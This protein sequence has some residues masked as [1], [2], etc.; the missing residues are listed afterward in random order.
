MSRFQRVRSFILGILYLV[1]SLLLLL[2]PKGSYGVITLIISFMLLFYSIRQLIYYVRMARHMVGGKIILCEA[3]IIL[4]LGLF[5]YSLYDDKSLTIL[6]FLLIIYAFSGFVDI[7]RAFEAKKNDSPV[8]KKKIVIGFLE[9]G[10]AITMIVLGL[11]FRNTDFLVYGFAIS[12]ASSG[13]LRIYDAFRKTAI[14]Y[15]Q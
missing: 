14:V 15:I 8:W 11:V 7:L 2:L 9:M 1:I 10:L 4:D 12:L 6:I 3:I 5:I 13:I